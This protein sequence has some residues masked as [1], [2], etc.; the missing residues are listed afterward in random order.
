MFSRK[1]PIPTHFRTKHWR[2]C[3]YVCRQIDHRFM[4]QVRSASCWNKLQEFKYLL[5]EEK[6]RG[7]FAKI[8]KCYFIFTDWCEK[9]LFNTNFTIIVTHLYINAMQRTHIHIFYYIRMPEAL[10]LIFDNL[11]R[12]SNPSQICFSAADFVISALNIFCIYI[13]Y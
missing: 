13:Y 3:M 5:S 6:F 7:N 12:A 1:R 8:Q 10:W 11:S 9:L 2:A 4:W